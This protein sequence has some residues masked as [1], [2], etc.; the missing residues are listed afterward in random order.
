M[1]RLLDITETGYTYL[2]C[3]SHYSQDTNPESLM[4]GLYFFFKDLFFIYMST[5]QLSS[6]HWKS[7]LDPISGSCEPLCGCWE[8]ST[9]PLAEQSVLLTAEPSLQPPFSFFF[10]DFIFYLSDSI[11]MVMT[12]YPTVS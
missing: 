5:L 8:L 10:L 4:F 1:L 2:L 7:A 11:S 9:R 6:V 12:T 3:C